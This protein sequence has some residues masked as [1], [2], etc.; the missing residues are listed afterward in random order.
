M[1]KR[2]IFTNPPRKGEAMTTPGILFSNLKTDYKK[3]SVPKPEVQ[4]RSRSAEKKE[5]R[6]AFKPPSILLD[7]PFQADKE[8]YGEDNKFL[9]ILSQQSL[10]VILYLLLYNIILYSFLIFEFKWLILF[11]NLK[12]FI[13]LITDNKFRK[14]R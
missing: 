6:F 13:L 4:K 7:A 14:R 8:V 5:E 10:E 11:K 2:G 1:E 9:K 12:I 3:G